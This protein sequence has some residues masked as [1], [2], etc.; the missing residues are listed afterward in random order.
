[1]I[2]FISDGIR[3]V[4]C[5]TLLQFLLNDKK[6][7]DLAFLSF[8]IEDD[9]YVHCYY[10]YLHICILFNKNMF[11]IHKKCRI[12]CQA[13]GDVQFERQRVRA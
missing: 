12:E 6:K 4:I 8:S 9:R 11:V 13:V 10:I 1:M 2:I 3:M 7:K 5:C